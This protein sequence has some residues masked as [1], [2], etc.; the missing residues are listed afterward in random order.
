M[1]V[2]IAC[3]AILLV[4]L[5]PPGSASP[6]HMSPAERERLPSKSALRWEHTCHQLS[7]LS[8]WRV[9]HEFLHRR[10]HKS[11]TGML[12]CWLYTGRQADSLTP[13]RP[14]KHAHGI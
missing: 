8:A 13:R 3:T 1:V 4:S 9:W 2:L 10:T 12:A 6:E 5:L 7:S 14:D 11:H